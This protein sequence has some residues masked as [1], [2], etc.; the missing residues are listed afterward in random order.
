M[1]WLKIRKHDIRKNNPKQDSKVVVWLKIRKH[2]IQRTN[3]G[4]SR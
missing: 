3:G 4:A 2:D 1:V